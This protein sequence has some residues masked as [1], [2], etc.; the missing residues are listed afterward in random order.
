MVLLRKDLS[1]TMPNPLRNVPNAVAVS[2]RETEVPVAWR[3]DWNLMEYVNNYNLK[4]SGS[5]LL[6]AHILAFGIAFGE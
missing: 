3:G 4:A 1:L 2:Q 6:A 5:A